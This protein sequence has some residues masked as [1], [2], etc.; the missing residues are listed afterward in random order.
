MA[1]SKIEE[2]AKAIKGIID[3]VYKEN[4]LD[5]VQTSA[6]YLDESGKEI[7]ITPYRYADPAC[8]TVYRNGNVGIILRSSRLYP[9]QLGFA[10]LVAD[11]KKRLE[12]NGYFNIKGNLW[13]EFYIIDCKYDV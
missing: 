10:T 4:G 3:D 6:I 13:H 12:E 9:L 7:L 5:N 11:T 8:V 1:S 2:R